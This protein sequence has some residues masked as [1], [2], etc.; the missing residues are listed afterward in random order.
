MSSGE[1]YIGRREGV[2]IGIEATAG[3]AVAP[4]TWLAWLN[5]DLMSK[6]GV[7]ENTSALGVVDEINDSEVASRWAEGKIGGKVTVTSVGYLLTGF[8]GSPTT[9]SESGGYYP[10]TFEMNQSSAP[11]PALTFAIANSI[12]SQRFAYGVVDSL[13]ITAETG[14]WVE[15]AAAVKARLGANSTETV[16]IA[17]E[18]EFASKHIHVKMAAN[19]AGLGAA[20][21]ISASRVQLTLERPS[22]AHNA[23]GTSDTPEFDRLSFK[24]TGELVLRYTDTQYEENFLANTVRALSI[25]MTNG[26]DELEFVASKVR[27]RELERTPDRDSIITQT[28]SLAAEFDVATGRSIQAVLTNEQ[29]TY[30]SA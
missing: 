21:D 16:A 29:A 25:T 26:S 13:E 3:T 4:Q 7:I 23:L 10:H 12:Q 6:T 1:A 17:E 30:A 20:S 18:T 14:G 5:Q 24:V 22:E 8:F 19:V 11:A 27:T 9:G 2:G 15:V 28:L